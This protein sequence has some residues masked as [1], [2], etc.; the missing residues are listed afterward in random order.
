MIWSFHF[1]EERKKGVKYLYLLLFKILHYLKWTSLEIYIYFIYFVYFRDNSY[2]YQ[3]IDHNKYVFL[4]L[5]HNIIR[6]A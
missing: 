5:L 4:I 1:Q 2:S 6:N 3:K